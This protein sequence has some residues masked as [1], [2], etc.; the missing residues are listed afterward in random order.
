VNCHT[1]VVVMGL[2]KE[3]GL[4][5]NEALFTLTFKDKL[6]TGYTYFISDYKT[7]N[8]WSRRNEN[9]RLILIMQ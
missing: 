4:K 9:G 3:N 2:T 7:V 8:S 5:L 1:N 6:E